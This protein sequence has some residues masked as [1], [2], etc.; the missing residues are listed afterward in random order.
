MNRSVTMLFRS[1]LLAGLPCILAGCTAAGPCVDDGVPRAQCL[2]CR[3]NGDL[4]CVCVKVLPDTPR[5][6]YRGGTF[7][8]CSEDCRRDFERDPQRYL[9]K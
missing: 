3:K 2:V 7:Y 9:P 6:E 5:T 4:A 1:A 8:F